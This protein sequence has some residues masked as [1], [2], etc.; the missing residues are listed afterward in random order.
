MLPN[1][2]MSMSAAGVRGLKNR[3]SFRA[4]PY[5]DHN[6]FDKNHQPIDWHPGKPLIGKL[7]V[8][9]GRVIPISAYEKYKNI[10]E[11]QAT[12]MLIEDLR[13]R[14]NAIRLHVLV[15]LTQNEYDALVIFIY[16][17][18]EGAFLTSTLLKMLNKGDKQ[19]A[20]DQ[21]MRWIYSNGKPI[22]VTRRQYERTIFIRG[23]Y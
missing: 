3:E 5:D 6:S 15:P 2:T 13:P 19:G 23:K 1:A 14:E 12:Q 17:I 10:T 20:A 18:G 9:Y 16:N 4:R 11:V 22:L 7:T 21:F 8:G